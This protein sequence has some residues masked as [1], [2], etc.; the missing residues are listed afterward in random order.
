MRTKVCSSTG[1]AGADINSPIPLMWRGHAGAGADIDSPITFMW[2][3]CGQRSARERLTREPSTTQQSQSNGTA[4]PNTQAMT[5]HNA[6][7]VDQD[8]STEASRGNRPTM[9]RSKAPIRKGRPGARDEAKRQSLWAVRAVARKRDVVRSECLYNPF[10]LWLICH[11]SSYINA[12]AWLR[13]LIC[14]NQ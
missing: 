11:G 12:R 14:K 1:D 13:L 3:A 6:Q 8:T 9:P 7:N 10:T 5:R 4:W 2:R